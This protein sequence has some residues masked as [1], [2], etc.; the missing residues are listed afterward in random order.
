MYGTIGPIAALC[1][2]S[3]PPV[4][5]DE[6][7]DHDTPDILAETFNPVLGDS[8]ATEGRDDMAD[9]RAISSNDD[10][11]PLERVPSAQTRIE[12]VE[13]T[14]P[15]PS[16]DRVRPNKDFS[17]KHLLDTELMEFESSPN[18][19]NRCIF[20]WFPPFFTPQFSWLVD[21][22]GHDTASAFVVVWDDPGLAQI[23]SLASPYQINAFFKTLWV[24]LFGD[25]LVGNV[26]VG[27]VKY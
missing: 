22:F 26:F 17:Y 9:E 23:I 19:W 25:C 18:V 16:T 3:Y 20:R 21:L 14:S 11:L 4:N 8:S 15:T 10:V 5:I 2:G 1:T 13:I 6:H 24:T 7:V 12:Q 27:C